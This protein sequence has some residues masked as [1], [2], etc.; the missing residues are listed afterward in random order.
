MQCHQFQTSEQLSG[1]LSE[2][3]ALTDT[4][5]LNRICFSAITGRLNGVIQFFHIA[6][7]AGVKAEQLLRSG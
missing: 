2:F 3:C 6:I 1:Y 4:N 5:P 7:S